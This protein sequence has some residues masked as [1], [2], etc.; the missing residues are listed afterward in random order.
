ML[1]IWNGG[2]WL[3]RDLAQPLYSWVERGSPIYGWFIAFINEKS[4][5]LIF[6]CKGTD[7]FM[8]LMADMFIVFL[9]LLCWLYAHFM[10]IAMYGSQHV[11]TC[12]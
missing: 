8:D 11:F 6:M 7:V 5:P 9:F 2:E 10:K 4:I 1:G 3:K 12:M